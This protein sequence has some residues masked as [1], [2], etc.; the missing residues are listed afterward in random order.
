MRAAFFVLTATLLV[1]AP[2]S[3]QLKVEVERNIKILK[4]S[5]KPAEIKDAIGRLERSEN[6]K[7]GAARE[8][9]PLI[10]KALKDKDATVRA[11][12]ASALGSLMYDPETWAK[13]LAPLL[14]EKETRDARWYA[15]EALADLGKH[16][17]FALDAL[18]SLRDKEAAKPDGMR[19][20]EILQL[21]RAAVDKL[22]KAQ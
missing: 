9:V 20:N 22:K 8:A 18:T 4:T 15:V 6:L 12:A 14:D 2:A 19:D 16:G 17:T 10:A 5:Q 13:D 1:S 11:A 21:Y 7:K 3:A